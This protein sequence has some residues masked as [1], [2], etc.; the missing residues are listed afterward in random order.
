M[1]TY[2]LVLYFMGLILLYL[3]CLS[4]AKHNEVQDVLRWKSQR[5]K[6]HKLAYRFSKDLSILVQAQSSRFLFAIH[7]HLKKS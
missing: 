6:I 1:R 3:Q 5:T 4:T 2:L 7:I